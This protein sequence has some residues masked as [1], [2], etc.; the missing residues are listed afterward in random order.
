MLI[1]NILFVYLIGSISYI[2]SSPFSTALLCN[3]KKEIHNLEK[4]I[5]NSNPLFTQ[6]ETFEK[7][8]LTTYE[9]CLKI[10]DC[11][12]NEPHQQARYC[13]VYSIIQLKEHSRNL[14]HDHRNASK[15]C[16]KCEAKKI[17]A[18][19]IQLLENTKST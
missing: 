11:D 18:Q 1:K 8:F 12:T 6:A 15:Q 2:S 19:L 10:H 14:E 17:K 4:Q 5:K 16:E 3:R 7:Y 9:E 13:M